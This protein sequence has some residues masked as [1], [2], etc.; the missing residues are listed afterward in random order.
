VR[1]HVNGQDRDAIDLPMDEDHNL[2]ADSMQAYRGDPAADSDAEPVGKGL[3]GDGLTTFEEYRGF[4]IAGGDCASEADDVVV[5]TDPA[6]KDLFVHAPD[7]ELAAATHFEWASGVTTHQI[8]ARQFADTDRRIVNFTLQQANLREWHGRTISQGSPQHGLYIKNEWPKD[9]WGTGLACG[10]PPACDSDVIGPPKYTASILIDKTRVLGG[11]LDYGDVTAAASG[12][13]RLISTVTHETGHGVGM[14]HHGDEVV[15]WQIKSHH[16]NIVAAFYEG[17]MVV[18]PNPGCTDPRQGGARQAPPVYDGHGKLIGCL[19]TGVKVRSGQNS[20]AADCPM[21]YAE[22]MFYEAPGEN[23]VA[24]QFPEPD[25]WVMVLG[26]VLPYDTPDP[27]PIGKFC[28]RAGGTGINDKA[29]G[30]RSHTGDA[31]VGNCAGQ[32]VINDLAAPDRK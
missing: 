32:I 13:V 27:P 19:T 29:R 26:R 4:A 31:A 21:R 11:D 30:D 22:G 16:L 25:A 6:R 24:H 18:E 1:I 23:V 8:C 15:N 7:P 28:V 5:R 10:N 3:P 12:V 14:P 20:G 17:D 9:R 2:I